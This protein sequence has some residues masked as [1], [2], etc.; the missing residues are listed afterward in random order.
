MNKLQATVYS[1]SFR[2]AIHL[3]R[4]LAISEKTK[5]KLQQCIYENIIKFR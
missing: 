1:F 3:R 4:Q 2:P 5:I